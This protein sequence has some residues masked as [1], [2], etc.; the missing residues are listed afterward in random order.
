MNLMEALRNNF[1]DNEVLRQQLL[2]APKCGNNDDYVDSIASDILEYA[3]MEFYQHETP[4]GG[5]YIACIN[6]FRNFGLWGEKI[7]ATPD[8][9]KA[10]QPLADSTGSSQGFDINGPTAL[11]NTV[12]KLPLTQAIG[13]PVVN[14]RFQKQ[15][16]KDEKNLQKIVSLIRAY[17]KQGGLQLQ[18]LVADTEEMKDAQKNPEAHKNLIVRVGGYSARFNDLS[19]DIQDSIIVRTEHAV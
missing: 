19:K 4:R 13:T 9:R 6:P 2:Q 14:I 8:G 17:F 18:I 15:M 3:G 7:A 1:D 11:L 10:F 5:R 12:T 16:M